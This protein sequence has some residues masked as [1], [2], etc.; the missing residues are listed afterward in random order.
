MTLSVLWCG[1]DKSAAMP[2]WRGDALKRRIFTT[3]GVLSQPQGNK[4]QVGG[5]YVYLLLITPCC[6]Q[7]CHPVCTTVP[8]SLKH[9]ASLVSPPLS[10]PHS[11]TH[12][13]TLTLFHRTSHFSP[14]VSTCLLA[15]L[16]HL[17]SHTLHRSRLLTISTYKL[18]YT[19][20]TPAN[21]A[22]PSGSL[23]YTYFFPKSRKKQDSSTKK[24]DTKL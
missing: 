5:T 21:V 1:G 2:S 16:L 23:S 12:S 7:L 19:V 4:V 13:L 24:Q 20:F 22:L 11:L 18:L 3:K 15:A 17:F 8:L 14:P 9:S 10:K 6:L